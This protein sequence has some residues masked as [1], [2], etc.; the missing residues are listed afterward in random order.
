MSDYLPK[1]DAM[2]SPFTYEY[3]RASHH[4]TSRWPLVAV[5][6]HLVFLLDRS[7]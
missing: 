1:A 6:S 5:G 3:T 7:R 4:A 2:D